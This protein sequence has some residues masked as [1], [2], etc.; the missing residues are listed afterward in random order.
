MKKNENFHINSFKRNIKLKFLVLVE[1]LLIDLIFQSSSSVFSAGLDIEEMYE[2][3][4]ERLSAFWSN[5]QEAYLKLYGHSRPV[6]AAI[7]VIYYK[8]CC[9]LT[10]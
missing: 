2:P 1:C 8:V 9:Q 3:K 5:L 6:I 7:N 10:I 4:K